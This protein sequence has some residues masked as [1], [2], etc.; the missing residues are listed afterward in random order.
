MDDERPGRDI[1]W[2]RVNARDPGVPPE[3][4]DRHVYPVPHG[5]AVLAIFADLIA[6]RDRKYNR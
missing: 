1:R 4:Q 2:P 5:A 3:D 6:A